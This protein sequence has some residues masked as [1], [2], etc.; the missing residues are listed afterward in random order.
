MN[1]DI[2]KKITMLVAESINSPTIYI[3]DITRDLEDQKIEYAVI[4]AQALRI[5][6]YVR[7]TEDID[8]LISKKTAK[9][10]KKLIGHGYTLIP[11][12]TKNLYYHSPVRKIQIDIL[13][14][15]QKEGKITMPDPTKIRMKINK[16]WYVDLANLINLKIDSGRS[17]DLEDVKI[18]IDENDLDKSFAEKIKNKKKFLKL[19][20]K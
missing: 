19:L 5:H 16:V 6:N 11:G 13:I 18:L 3:R 15:G 20:L 7:N 10:L 9:K 17:R 8:I 14:E 12:S 1:S 4:G 2:I